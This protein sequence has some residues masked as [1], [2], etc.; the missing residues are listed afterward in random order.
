MGLVIEKT[1]RFDCKDLA[2]VKSSL[3]INF[4]Q[5][6]FLSVTIDGL[7]ICVSYVY[8]IGI[9]LYYYMPITHSKTAN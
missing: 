1:V 7:Y 3:I 6:R 2:I 4:S 5:I 8:D 9:K